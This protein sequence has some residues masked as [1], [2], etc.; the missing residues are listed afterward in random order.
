MQRVKQQMSLI[1]LYKAEGSEQCCFCGFSTRTVEVDKKAACSVMQVRE[2][3][4][5]TASLGNN[6]GCSI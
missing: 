3:H 4:F 5:T 2:E 1:F 6:D